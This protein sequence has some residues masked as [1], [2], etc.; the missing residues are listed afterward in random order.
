MKLYSIQFLRALAALLVVYCHSLDLQVKHAVSHQQNFF[1][2]QD[3][4]AIG[5]DIFFVIS[6]FIISFIGHNINGPGQTYEFL[7]KRFARI[8]PYYYLVSVIAFAIFLSQNHGEFTFKS[9]LKTMTLLPVEPGTEIWWPVLAIGWTLSFEWFF[10]L[11]FAA[12]IYKNIKSKEVYLI[13]MLLILVAIGVTVNSPLIIIQFITH[14]IILEFGAGALLGWLFRN[15]RVPNALAFTSLI[16]SIA[17]FVMLI[18][19]G[20]GRVSESDEVLSGR[21]TFSRLFYFGIP[22]ILLV[23]GCVFLEAGSKLR[24]IWENPTLQLLGNASY[25]IY[26]VHTIV[27]SLLGMLYDRLGMIGPPDVLILI[28]LAL[29]TIFG[30]ICHLSIEKKIYTVSIKF[31]D[32]VELMFHKNYSIFKAR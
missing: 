4:G 15:K 8:N 25:S 9:V 30:V 27:F 23:F 17:C 24:T 16:I 28:Q 22:S 13:I 3:F 7:K 18:Q 32:S 20:Y 6:G 2:L 31:L 1:H 29:A 26:L 10:Y 5:V 11:L 21:V 19:S 14:P 12:L